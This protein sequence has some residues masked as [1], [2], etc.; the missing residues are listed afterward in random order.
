MKLFSIANGLNF[1][2]FSGS[3]LHLKCVGYNC[4]FWSCKLIFSWHD[5]MTTSSSHSAISLHVFNYP[6]YCF[7]LTLITF[8]H[9]FFFEVCTLRLIWTLI[10]SS[11]VWSSSLQFRQTTI[12]LRP[13]LC[14]RIV[15]ISTYQGAV[16]VLVY[17]GI[18]WFSRDIDSMWLFMQV[19]GKKV[20]Q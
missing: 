12:C 2:F 6:F 17:S 8:C 19:E 10:F 3:I 16:T 1:S 7:N 14:A 11:L 20:L 4:G 5:L 18:W 13:V 15:A 9:V